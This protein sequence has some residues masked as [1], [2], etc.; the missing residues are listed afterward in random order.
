MFIITSINRFGTP[1]RLT[2][3]HSI[4]E[5]VLHPKSKR[6]IKERPRCVLRRQAA[7]LPEVAPASLKYGRDLWEDLRPGE[8]F[9]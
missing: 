2:V 5:I 7:G 4:M 1:P 6:Q 8:A 9:S 3:I